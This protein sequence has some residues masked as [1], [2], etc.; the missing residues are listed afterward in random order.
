M[1]SFIDKR[2]PIYL[3][4]KQDGGAEFETIINKLENG[5]EQRISTVSQSLA[6]WSFNDTNAL[7][8]EH[9]SLTYKLI[10]DLFNVARGRLFC[11]RYRDFFN[12]AVEKENGKLGN[13]FGNS[14]P[15]HQLKKHT[16]VSNKFFE[17]DITLPLI[18]TVKIYANDV[19]IPSSK[20][21]VNPLSGR[22]TL[23][24]LKKVSIYSTS[25][26]SLTTTFTFINGSNHTFQLNEKV[27]INNTNVLSNLYRKVYT[28]IEV[29]INS[30]TIN[31]TT[32]SSLGANSFIEKYY[33]SS[34][35]LSA[36]FE[37]DHLVRFDNKRLSMSF[38]NG[39][40]KFN[41]LE[42]IEVRDKLTDEED[43]ES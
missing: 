14:K 28:I 7:N 5:S 16:E 6:S 3:S 4:S 29:T 9:E 13:G 25:S 22:V 12:N 35:S 37:Y 23:S 27:Y 18:N 24:P 38:D 32:S 20:F 42:L 10:Q 34:V 8:N 1:A 17:K 26:T 41:G 36:E 11:F 15:F 40:V 43:L 39:M 2:F 21:N 33:D 30:I 19:E 31:E